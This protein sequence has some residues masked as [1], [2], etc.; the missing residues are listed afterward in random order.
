M[1][2]SS[3]FDYCRTQNLLI[4]VGMNDAKI[5]L[6]GDRKAAIGTKNLNG[7]SAIMIMGTQ[8][9]VCAHIA[10]RAGIDDDDYRAHHLQWL[11]AAL[12]LY[13]KHRSLFSPNT[14]TWG[15]FGLTE[16]EPLD[17]IVELVKSNLKA[18]GLDAKPAYYRV[19]PPVIRKPPMGELI[20]VVKK[21]GT[22]VILERQKLEEK[23]MPRWTPQW[24]EGAQPAAQP[25]RGS[26]LASGSKSS[27]GAYKSPAPVVSFEDEAKSAQA[28]FIRMCSSGADRTQAFEALVNSFMQQYPSLSKQDATN[29]MQA[30]LSHR[31]KQ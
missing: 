24:S 6:P 17:H 9:I 18:N 30:R 25:P 21:E 1:D 20:A 29:G 8:A 22:Q 3:V 10:P 26:V 19:T 15:I 27:S 7:C 28:A 13:T 2:N 5:L 16:G 14:T 23:A 31:R 11:R 4:E 12:V